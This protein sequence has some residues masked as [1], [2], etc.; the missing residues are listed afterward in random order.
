MLHKNIQG[1]FEIHKSLIE[2]DK[3][4]KTLKSDS[5]NSKIIAL[6][7]IFVII[8]LFV[9][10]YFNR[11][12]I[13]SDFNV[14]KDDLTVV[15]FIDSNHEKLKIKTKNLE[16]YVLE[17]RKVLKSITQESDKVEQQNKIDKLYKDLHLR[18]VNSEGVGGSHSELVNKLNA[19]FFI[20]FQSLHPEL[21]DSE[22]VICYYISV[23]FKNKE[24]ATFLN[25]SIRSLESKRFRISKKINLAQNENLADYLSSIYRSIS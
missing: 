22:I 8:V 19:K 23:G 17:L 9:F 15:S 5:N 13:K 1:T 16:E 3:K 24:I 25:S 7:L 6:I 20:E 2:S 14:L 4:I 10:Y 21:N 12:K 18:T 11:K